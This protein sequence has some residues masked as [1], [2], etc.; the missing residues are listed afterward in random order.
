MGNINQCRIILTFEA[1]RVDV[2]MQEMT[3]R[4]KAEIGG[5]LENNSHQI[6]IECNN[7]RV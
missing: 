5:R 7:Q 4:G 6:A 3:G 1:G 2:R